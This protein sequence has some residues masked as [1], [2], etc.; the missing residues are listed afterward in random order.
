MPR[1]ISPVR[2]RME[3]TVFRI[4][5]LEQEVRETQAEYD[6]L[7]SGMERRISMIDD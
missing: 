2:N 7:L 6:A 4:M 5:A 3:G 1:T